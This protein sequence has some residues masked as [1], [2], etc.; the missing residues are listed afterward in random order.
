ME[1]IEETLFNLI[2]KI[3]TTEE[4][5]LSDIPCVDLYVDQVTTFFNDKLQNLKRDDEDKILTKTMI[6]NYAKAKLLL[7]IKGKKY[8]KDQIILLS[9]IYNLK[10]ILSINDIGL[11]LSPII[12]NFSKDKDASSNLEKLYSTFLELIKPQSNEFSHWLKDKIKLV[13]EGDFYTKDKNDDYTILIL[14]VLILINSANLHK[15]MAE[16]IID[17]FFKNKSQ[18]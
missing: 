5:K 17:E 14:I 12:E 8:S 6:N 15:R 10:Q 11:I 4:I 18:K 9:L 13:G 16:K 2:E 7:P 1:K 3:C